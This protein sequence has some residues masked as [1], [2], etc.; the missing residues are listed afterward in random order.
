MFYGVG[1]GGEAVWP[2]AL[3]P[4]KDAGQ[5][6][7]IAEDVYPEERSEDAAPPRKAICGGRRYAAGPQKNG[8]PPRPRIGPS[9]CAHKRI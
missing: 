8:L 4:P 7:I 1:P 6:A 9:P 5:A 2:P 3:R